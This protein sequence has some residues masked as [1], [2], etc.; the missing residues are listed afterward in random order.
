MNYA[1]SPEWL[2]LLHYKSLTFGGYEGLV[3]NDKFYADEEGR[4]NP[5]KEMETEIKL[6]NEGDKIKCEFPARFE[7]LK[8]KGLV[9]GNLDDCEEYQSFMND[10]KPD[11]ITVLFT[12][13]YM[14]NPASLFGHTLIRIDTARKGTQMLAHGSNFG[15]NSGDDSGPIY[16]FKGLVG[17][18]YGGYV[19]SPY[20]DVINTYNNIENRDIWEYH[21]NLTLK[22][23]NKFVNHL[24]EMKNALIRY[25][26]LNKNCSYMILELLEAVRPEL[27]VTADYN[28]WAIPLD[29]LK[30]IKE[31]PD[32]VDNVN[33][34]PSRYTKIKAQTKAMNEGQFEAFYRGIKEHD[35]DME[36]L[37]ETEQS[38][39]LETQYQY[40]QYIYTAGYMELKDYRKNSFAVLRKRSSMPE[41]ETVK[42][43]GEEPNLS[44]AS[45][46][47]MFGGGVYNHKSFEQI[48]LRP[49]Y[50]ALTDD[51]WG[52]IKGA[53]ISVLESQFRYYNQNHK[54]VLHR[55]TGLKIDSFVPA[56]KIFSPWSYI[57][58]FNIHREY[59]PSNNHEGYVGEIKFG[60]GKTYALFDWFWLYGI[61]S[62][63]GQYG[64]FIREN[65]W[66]GAAP[67]IGV[68]NDFGRFKA[69]FGAEK[70]FATRKFGSRLIYKAET[71]VN[72]TK[73]ISFAVM[74]N[75]S[76]NE[77]GHNRQELIG[78]LRYSY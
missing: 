9:K 6:F 75:M 52:L 49:A 12:N 28:Y 14:S 77:S 71:S 25:F 68:F 44:H 72:F 56:D 11:G 23:Q 33:Y 48:N 50:T 1:E 37:S 32:L 15:A 78:Q 20:W 73:D 62:A 67:E 57:S 53:G 39:V 43:Q 31:V 7:W 47:I 64:G 70:D 18:Y 26:F 54:A 55:F 36:N 66:M 40:Y 27:N 30:T 42:P 2:K 65:Q 45:A 5:Q 69:N 13:A 24:Y 76:H 51:N 10:V 60:M 16:A 17:G 63:K 4:Y 29:T 8:E 35:Y 34:R 59:N 46:Q 61:L 58:D 3:D 21:L 38:A 41:I 74:Y 19:I 22:E